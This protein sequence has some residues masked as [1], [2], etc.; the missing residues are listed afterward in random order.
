MSEEDRRVAMRITKNTSISVGLGLV[1]VAAGFYSGVS[2]GRQSERM[3]DH[4]ALEMHV[5][6]K[7]T[8]R[9][10]MPRNELETNFESIDDRLDDIQE[11]QK[12][13]LFKLNEK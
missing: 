4:E 9:D 6:S 13:I 12:Q 1:I 7:Q 11:T 2:Y 8:L 10:Y 3:D 5:G